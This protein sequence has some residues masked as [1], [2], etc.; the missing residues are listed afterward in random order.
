MKYEGATEKATS[1]LCSNG[2]KMECK[3]LDDNECDHCKGKISSNSGMAYMYCIGAHHA[4]KTLASHVQTKVNAYASGAGEKD[5]KAK[6]LT[7]WKIMM[8]L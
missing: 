7:L 3:V 4:T 8:L 1:P 5:G 6:S 2:H